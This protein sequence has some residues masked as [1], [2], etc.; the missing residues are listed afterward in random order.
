MAF[1]NGYWNGVD[2]NNIF[3]KSLSDAEF[4]IDNGVNNVGFLQ[5]EEV[6]EVEKVAPVVT[7][8]GDCLDVDTTT[9]PLKWCKCTYPDP[10]YVADGPYDPRCRSW[11]MGAMRNK[12]GI[13]LSSPYIDAYSG[14]AIQ[15]F[16]RYVPVGPDKKDSVQSID[17]GW[18]WHIY[19]TI[20]EDMEILDQYFVVDL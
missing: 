15:T 9:D 20:L 7:D 11:Y 18:S 1:Y 4:W 8:S 3:I 17:I 2:Y 16:A 6:I 13:T 10:F 14:K 12:G 19:K 5:L